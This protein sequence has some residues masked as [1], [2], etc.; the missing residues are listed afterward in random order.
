VLAWRRVAGDDRRLVVVNF[1]PDEVAWNPG[2]IIEIASNGVGE[3]EP[4]TGH[5]APDQALILHSLNDHPR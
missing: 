1:G 5:L 2:G 3:G 4:F